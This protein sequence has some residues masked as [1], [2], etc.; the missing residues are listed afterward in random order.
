MLTAM[1]TVKGR[2]FACLPSA[3]PRGEP[4]RQGLPSR[5]WRDTA[6][7]TMGKPVASCAV[8]N[9]GP[10]NRIAFHTFGC[11]LNQSET[12]IMERSFEVDGYTIVSL[13]NNPDI[14]VV[15]TCTVTEN[16]DADTR[17]LV[18]RIHRQN[19]R[20]RIALV[21]CQAQIQK[22]QLAKLP[23]VCWV[24]GNARKME[25]ASLIRQSPWPTE[26]QII[27]PAIPRESFTLP[28]AGIDRRHTRANLK[29]QD[30][31][32][33]FCTFCEIP[34]ARGRARS[35]IFED[36]L[37]EAHS[38]VAAGHKELVLTG[39]NI[40]TYRYQNKTLLD[41]L[42]QLEKLDDLVRVR[43]SSIEPTTI[44]F[45][46]INR[47]GKTKLCRYLHIPLQSASDE[48]LRG[49][50]RKYRSHEF[51]EFIRKAHETVPEIC[52]GTDIIVGFPGET[53]EDF[54]KTVDFIR[55]LPFSYCHIFSYSDRTYNKSNRLKTKISKEII[56]KRS[57]ILR[58]LSQ[59][60]RFLFLQ[61]LL[62]TTQTVLFEENKNGFWMGRTDNYAKV[63]A[64][65][66]IGL[67]NRIAKVKL[68]Q[69][70]DQTAI[71]A[72]SAFFTLL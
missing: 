30:G 35:R 20:V 48:V 70:S 32:D 15:N 42:D 69:I 57:A 21:G 61:N 39:I 34:Y 44:P 23:N 55:E 72:I 62:G 68:L 46:L 58:H 25:L 19:P 36:I 65:S 31:C 51:A 11:R 52:I 47:M 27:T 67:L 12:A 14:V 22:E 71:G 63:Q 59:R 16:G 7:D 66:S 5:L 40:G 2:P 53:E 64:P 29:I 18:S 38:L 13:N 6:S 41:I 37:K 45:E 8:K 43:I 26:T 50:K 49:M 56:Q 17:R 3:S 4:D 24:V 28:T 33:F 1:N 60:K 54:Q 9:P 10:L